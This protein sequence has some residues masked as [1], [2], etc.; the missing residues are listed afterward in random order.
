M[1]LRD[2]FAKVD[3]CAISFNSN[4]IDMKNQK[5]VLF[6]LT[7][8]DKL[9][10]TS[11][12]TGFWIEEFA[13]PYY[14][15]TDHKILV[16]IATP[17]GGQAPIDPK[18]NDPS[19]QTDATKRYFEDDET[20]KLVAKTMRIKE[21]DSSNYDAVFYPGDHGPLWDL[22]NDQDS[23]SLIET[24]YQSNKPVAFVCHAP[25]ALKSATLGN[26]KP[27]ISG[28]KLT[29]FSNSEEEAVGLHKVVPFAVEEMIKSNGGHYE[30]AEDWSSFVV[31]DGLLITGQNP[32][33]SFQ[34]ANKLLERLQ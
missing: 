10:S 12:K 32:Q 27:L 2:S 23:I 7:S 34:V 11:E 20:Q 9:G 26:S 3:I 28:K 17:K 13:S 25:A 21:V 22:A 24:F 30:K 8:H 16:D 19:F 33:S 29:A 14:H 31:E 18:S 5:R 1:L 15:L 4:S 6:V